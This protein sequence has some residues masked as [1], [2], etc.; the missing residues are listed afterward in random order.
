V[1][2][3]WTNHAE[4]RAR[5]RRLNRADVERAIGDGHSARETN[6]GS[7][8]WLVRGKTADGTIFE[9]IY[10]HPHLGEENAARIVSAWRLD[11]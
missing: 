1:R 8:D 2:F 3:V 9:A 7:A 6:D 11:S 5:Q 10:D 4:A